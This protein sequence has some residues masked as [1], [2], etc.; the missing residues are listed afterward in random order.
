MTVSFT[1]T[2]DAVAAS[3]AARTPTTLSDDGAGQTVTGTASDNAGNTATDTATVNIDQVEPAI[4]AARDR[5]P[6]S[7]GW[8]NDDVTVSFT[9]ADALSG[10]AVVHRPADR[11]RGRGP[12][13]HRHRH[14]PRGQHRQVTDADINVDKT[15]PS[16]SGAADDRPQRQ[17]LVPRV[18]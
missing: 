16:I 7:N 8:Y 18:T 13:G 5:V 2:D 12:V 1:C 14:R 4:S 6:N 3:R 11:W 10:V 17:R 15:A 9:C